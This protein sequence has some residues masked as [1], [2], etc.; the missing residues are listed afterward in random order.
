M[1][2]V[3][4]SRTREDWIRFA[5]VHDCCLEPV[6]DLDEALESELVRAREMVV[7]L[8]QPGATRPVQLLGLPIKL[9]RTPGDPTRAPGPALGEHTDELLAAAGFDVTEIAR[10]HQQGA[11]AGTETNPAGTFMSG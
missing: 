6:L 5:E 11:V 8:A 10:L 9:G 2:D 3:F 4:R 7:T 1:C